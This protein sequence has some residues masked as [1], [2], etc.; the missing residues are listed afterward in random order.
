MKTTDTGSHVN[1]DDVT[2]F[3][4]PVIGYAMDDD[5][6]HRDTGAAGEP[7]VAQKAGFC[8]LALDKLAYCSIYFKGCFTGDYQF[9]RESAGRRGDPSGFAH[10]LDLMGGFN[11]NHLHVQI[12]S[13]ASTTL[14]VA[15][16]VG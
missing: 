3:E 1:A 10:E 6:V 5:L 16:M 9:S 13:A 7:P 12:P 2:L 11:G 4:H 8:A 15:S 14:V